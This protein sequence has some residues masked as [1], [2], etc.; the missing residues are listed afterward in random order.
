M[1]AVII[2][3]GG[4]APSQV[5]S[6]KLNMVKSVLGSSMTKRNLHLKEMTD[7]TTK[8][9]KQG[10]KGNEYYAIQDVYDGLYAKAKKV[11]YLMT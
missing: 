4:I 11:Q 1:E 7:Q 10:T 3:R 8:K 9:R 6:L 5:N 2:S